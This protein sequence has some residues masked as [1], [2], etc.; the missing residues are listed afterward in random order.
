MSNQQKASRAKAKTELR[1]TQDASSHTNEW[2]LNFAKGHESTNRYVAPFIHSTFICQLLRFY[3]S[4][5]ALRAQRSMLGSLCSVLRAPC[6][7][8]WAQRA[9]GGNNLNFS[10]P[11]G[12]QTS[13]CSSRNSSA[14]C[15]HNCVALAAAIRCRWVDCHCH[16]HCHRPVG[17]SATQSSRHFCLLLCLLPLA[18]A[19]FW[20]TNFE[21]IKALNFVAAISSALGNS[22]AAGFWLWLLFGPKSL[23]QMQLYKDKFNCLVEKAQLRSQLQLCRW[24]LHSQPQHTFSSLS[25]FIYLK[26]KSSWK[27]AGISSNAQQ[28]LTRF[29]SCHSNDTKLLHIVLCRLLS[30]SNTQFLLCVPYLK[31]DGFHFIPHT[32]TNAHV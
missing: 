5:S 17:P 23:G 30:V 19:T 6:S 22:T 7:V 2:P 8:C 3:F 16:C 14:I 24:H 4:F 27:R 15:P 1:E 18:G 26:I 13:S 20:P 21:E 25:R 31:S 29:L 12:I 9:L 28:M 32:Y 11:L 10:N